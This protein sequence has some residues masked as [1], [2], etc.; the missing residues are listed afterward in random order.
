[1][2]YP[3]RTFVPRENVNNGA[4]LSRPSSIALS[5]E[6][7]QRLAHGRESCQFLI[8]YVYLV[9]GERTGLATGASLIQFH[10]YGH[11]IQGKPKSLGA[12][13][14]VDLLYDVR[15]IAAVSHARLLRLR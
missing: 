1:M 2:L 4:S 14:K 5:N 7:G 6:S 9:D 11:F 12:L 15:R 8:D 13:D 3:I 10:E